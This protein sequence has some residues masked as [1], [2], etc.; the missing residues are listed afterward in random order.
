MFETMESDVFASSA[1]PFATS[2][3][4][5]ETRSLLGSAYKTIS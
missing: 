1:Q 5:A 2:S 3:A 4:T